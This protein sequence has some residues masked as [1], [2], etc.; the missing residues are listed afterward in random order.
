[1]SNTL[2][3]RTGTRLRTGGTTYEVVEDGNIP[4]NVVPVIPQATRLLKVFCA[5]CGYT[6]R[7]TQRWLTKAGTPLCP[8]G[9][10]AMD[11]AAKADAPT[12]T[13]AVCAVTPEPAKAKA[14]AQRKA[15]PEPIAEDDIAPSVLD[16]LL[17]RDEDDSQESTSD[18]TLAQLLSELQ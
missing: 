18:S 7:V 12:V 2:S 3:L 11:V 15:K 13:P 14:K 16:E 17:A 9:H 4:A 8:C 5:A 1:L 6:A 10:G